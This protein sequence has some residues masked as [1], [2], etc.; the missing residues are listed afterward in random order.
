MVGAAV[1]WN[2][3]VDDSC[4]AAGSVQADGIG[5]R[6]VT[7]TGIRCVVVLSASRSAVRQGPSLLLDQLA[8]ANISLPTA[9]CCSTLLRTH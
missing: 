4:R 5:Y 9:D 7:A 1:G 8:Q 3:A 6:V 2:E